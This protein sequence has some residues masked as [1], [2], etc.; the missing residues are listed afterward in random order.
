MEA[1]EYKGG[2]WLT[3]EMAIYECPLCGKCKIVI[4]K[5]ETVLMNTLQPATAC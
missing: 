2:T 3:P 5:P 1:V 4:Y